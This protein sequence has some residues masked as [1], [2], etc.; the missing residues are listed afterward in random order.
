MRRWGFMSATPVLTFEMTD[1]GPVLRREDPSLA[2]ASSLLPGGTYSTLRTYGGRGV[3]RFDAHLRRLQESAGLTGSGPSIDR[4]AAR[5]LVATALDRTRH[6][7]S[8]LRLTFAPP[9]LLVSV[10]AFEPL[11]RALYEA[12]VACVTLPR[13]RREKPRVKDTRFIPTALRAYRDLPPGVQEGLLVAKDG[14]ILEGLSSNFFSI[15][16]GAL[17]TEEDRALAGIT[18][19]LAI[20]AAE[21]QGCPVRGAASREELVRAEEAFLTSVSREVLPVVT[22]DGEPV[23]DGRVGPRVR[24]IVEAFADLIRRET[25]RI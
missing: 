5:G 4:E 17:C 2:D 8:R 22:I 3:V 9:R 19:T 14:A 12:G 21:S 15:V 1:D 10:E 13:V 18:R 7:E 25:E 23:G 16:D 20:E 6:P 24:A 11:P